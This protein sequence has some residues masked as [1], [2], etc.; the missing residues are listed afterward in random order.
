MIIEPKPCTGIAR[1]YWVTFANGM[2]LSVTT[3][4]LMTNIQ[5]IREGKSTLEVYAEPDKYCDNDIPEGLLSVALLDQNDEFIAL[6]DDLNGE[7]ACLFEVE[8]L[9]TQAQVTELIDRLRVEP[10]EVATW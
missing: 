3:A 6:K 7:D 2:K 9:L 4:M 1:G 8:R 10:K 5:A